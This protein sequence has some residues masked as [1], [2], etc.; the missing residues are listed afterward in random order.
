MLTPQS[1][2]VE[3]YSNSALDKQRAIR[4]NDEAMKRI[5]Y[6]T[7]R[8]KKENAIRQILVRVMIILQKKKW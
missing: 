6:T 7:S 1:S 2:L 4:I 8:I 3:I 5:D